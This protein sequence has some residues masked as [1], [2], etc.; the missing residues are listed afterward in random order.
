MPS[1]R[2]IAS[3]RVS[4][5]DSIT[6]RLFIL[7]APDDMLDNLAWQWDQFDDEWTPALQAD[8]VTW[9]D[10]RLLR[11]ITGILA[12]FHDQTNE[13]DDPRTVAVLARQLATRS[14]IGEIVAWVKT[15]PELRLPAALDAEQRG[16]RRGKLIDALKAMA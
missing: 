1:T 11:E 12:E 7:G 16:K 10:D 4:P 9:S 6:R 2:R 3:E 5:L 15:S 14:T 13:S 8:L